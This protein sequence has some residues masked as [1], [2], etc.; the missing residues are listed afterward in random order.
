MTRT[1]QTLNNDLT[2]LGI[3][4]TVAEQSMDKGRTAKA[5]AAACDPVDPPGVTS[6]LVAI[7]VHFI[8]RTR[9][10]PEALPTARFVPDR[11]LSA[12]ARTLALDDVPLLLLRAAALVALAAAVA[13]PVRRPTQ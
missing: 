13:A 1:L 6:K 8:T 12:R 7:A 5:H 4:H 3:A 10:H 11:P 9:P 2:A